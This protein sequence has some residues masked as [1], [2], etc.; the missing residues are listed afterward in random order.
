MSLEIHVLDKQRE[1]K[2]HVLK[3]KPTEVTKEDSKT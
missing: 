1:K 3:T 2:V